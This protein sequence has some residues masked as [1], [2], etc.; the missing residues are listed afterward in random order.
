M[1]RRKK[2]AGEKLE[3]SEGQRAG[4]TYI[5]RVYI[6][7][8]YLPFA[9]ERDYIYLIHIYLL[10]Y[11]HKS[12]IQVRSVQAMRLVASLAYFTGIFVKD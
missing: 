3:S 4:R 2:E 10:L 6:S 7:V 11:K 8:I 12:F 5:A 1:Q 9:I